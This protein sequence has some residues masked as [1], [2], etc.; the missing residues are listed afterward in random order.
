M[1]II[2]TVGCSRGLLEGPRQGVYV[3]HTHEIIGR[4]KRTRKER[5]APGFQ[6][7]AFPF[8]RCA[9]QDL[10]DPQVS[11]ELQDWT[12]LSHQQDLHYQPHDVPPEWR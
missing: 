3:G 4:F 2:C 10:A 5:L 1:N 12:L 9:E 6:L 7:L 8:W 11:G